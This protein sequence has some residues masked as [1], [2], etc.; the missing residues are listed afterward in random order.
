MLK[1]FSVKNYKNFKDGIK[2]SFDNVRDYSFNTNCINQGL[3]SKIIVFG[4]NASGKSNLGYA[5]FD[6]VGVLTDNRIVTQQL[7]NLY[8]AD[9]SSK[10]MEFSYEFQFDNDIV[11]YS[12]K[13]EETYNNLVFEELY[14]NGKTVYQFD[15]KKK[16][17][18]DNCNLELI[19]A[20]SLS[21]D[22]SNL[23]ISF[24]RVVANNTVQKEDDIVKKIIK[25]VN[26]MLFFKSLQVN[27]YIGLESSLTFI[28]DWIVNNG[29]IDDFNKFINQFTSNKSQLVSNKLLDHSVILEK[30]KYYSLNF[31]E[32]A[33][34]G[35]LSL[36]V[37]YF[38]YKKL[39]KVKFLYIDEFD[40][41]YH[42]ELSLSIIRL[43]LELKDIQIVLT[44]H[45][46]R[47]A[48]NDLLRP[49]CYFTLN[50]GKIKSFADSTE[51]ELRQGH[52]LEKMMRQGEFNV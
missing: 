1:S 31:K 36:E 47:L 37:F 10:I 7:N 44:S 42:M 50:D 2:L 27:D 39:D 45:N 12:Y 8:N 46:T 26:S 22:F 29:L 17:F 13:K 49:D 43:L 35:T 28:E 24:L 30:H 25:F 11:L 18:V 33:S 6:I 23:S 38:W 20:N 40:A 48:D 5:L 19:N 21:I 32:V 4:E 51:R 3:L 15:Y 34:S 52:N 41:F 16:E 14:F 9:S